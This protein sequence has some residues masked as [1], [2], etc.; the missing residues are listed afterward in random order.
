MFVRVCVCVRVSV[1]VCKCVCVHRCVCARDIYHVVFE[2]VLKYYTTTCSRMHTGGVL[3]L[4][5]QTHGDS[6]RGGTH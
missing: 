5:N 2:R 1:R 6:A 3:I 4:G